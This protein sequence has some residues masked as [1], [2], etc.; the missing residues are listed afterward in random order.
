MTIRKPVQILE[1]DVPYCTRTYGS[2]PCTAALGVTGAR[3]CY[4]MF[5]GCQDTANYD[6][7][8]I[9]LR[10][11]T[12]I[13]GLLKSEQI[14]PAMYGEIKGSPLEIS[15]SPTNERLGLMGQRESVTV[16]VGDF[17]DNDTQ[18]D[19]YQAE[20]V[21]GVAQSSGIG[22]D[23]EERGT[24]WGRLLKRWPY[25]YHAAARVRDG[26]VGDP[27]AS[28]TTRHYVISNIK[29]PGSSGSVSIELK[30]VLDLVDTK[31]FVPAVSTGKLSEAIDDTSLDPFTM[32][33]SGV[34]SEYPASGRICIGSEVMTFTRSG[35]V[36]T[37]LARAVD[38]TEASSHS[39]NDTVQTCYRVEAGEIDAVLADILENYADVDPAFIPTTDWANEA[40]TWLADLRLTRTIAKPQPVRDVVQGLLTLGVFIWWDKEAQEIKMRAN[41]PPNVGEAI[42]EFDASI[43]FIN[44]TFDPKA[45]PERRVTDVV[46]M[47]RI[48]DPTGSVTDGENYGKALTASDTEASGVNQYNGRKFIT[49]YCPWLGEGDDNIARAIAF[50]LLYRFR[51]V[52][53]RVSASIDIDRVSDA[54]IAAPVN[55]TARTFQDEDGASESRRFQVVRVQTEKNNRAGVIFESYEFAGR[56][57]FIT[58]NTRGD[59]GASS[60]SEI[61]AGTYLVDDATLLFA[62]G[63]GPYVFF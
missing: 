39:E 49:I 19:K 40:G 20:R 23:P 21:S 9:T 24:F 1:I 30:D 25:W 6:A 7:G 51:N 62:D 36:I 17:K 11:A 54:A 22:Y 18:L 38:G 12:S 60:A 48:L 61:E 4:N 59:Y 27:L 34:G 56:F 31:R 2:A 3:K 13:N 55:I 8:T 58:E 46:F 45:L 50:R 10:F 37:P 44:G 53:E 32:E 28:F 35:D 43:D 29:P 63:T 14:Y 57:G 5:S 16:E 52:P 15:V 42:A 47:H 26:Y 33:P 41:R